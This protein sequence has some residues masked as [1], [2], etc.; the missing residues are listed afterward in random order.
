MTID[1]YLSHQPD[2]WTA[3]LHSLT[4][5]TAAD[6]V[7]NDLRQAIERGDVT[8]GLRLP[9]ETSLAHSYAVSRSV[10]REALRS[11]A[12][13]GLT[14]TLTGKG[15]FV[16]ADRVVDDHFTIEETSVDLD[17]A[18]D[19]LSA[20][21]FSARDQIDSRPCIEIPAARWAAERRSLQQLSTLQDIV[22]RML[23]TD[24][25]SKWV[26]LNR[27]FHAVVAQASD[28]R[29]LQNVLTHLRDASVGQV[30]AVS[31][32]RKAESDAEHRRI[33]RAITV[34]SAPAADAAMAD[35]LASVDLGS[36]VC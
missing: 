4:R 29:V 32:H 28:N 15:T 26:A 10:V 34:R 19:H 36:G 9:S 1:T 21:E 13:L 22:A 27:R 20:S 11:C 16:V 25:M 7:L 3:G 8:V 23:C 33:L 5:V 18:P 12:S 6:A 14:K 35:H 24:D 2:S 31:T 17:R 30:F